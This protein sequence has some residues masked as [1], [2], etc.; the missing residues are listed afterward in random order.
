MSEAWKKFTTAMSNER[1]NKKLNRSGNANILKKGEIIVQ[2][3]SSEVQG[4]VQKYAR[5]GP[6]EFV[7]FPYEDITFKNLKDACRKHFESRIPEHMVCD[8]LA[9]DHG[10]SCSSLEQI[11]SFNVTHVRFVENHVVASQVSWGPSSI[12]ELTSTVQKNKRSVNNFPAYHE[13]LCK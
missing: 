2:R 12:Y 13:M 6:R 4:K 8:I 9:G 7:S 5:V 3:L 1:A 11:P 10:H